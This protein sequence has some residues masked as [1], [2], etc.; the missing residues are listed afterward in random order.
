MSL[1]ISLLVL[2]DTLLWLREDF[3]FLLRKDLE[4]LAAVNQNISF[5]H[6]KK[7]PLDSSNSLVF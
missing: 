1:G 7:K 5:H 6:L 4:K 3:L 2:M